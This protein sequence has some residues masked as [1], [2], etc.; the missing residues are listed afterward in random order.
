MS[1]PGQNDVVKVLDLCKPSYVTE[2]ND[3]LACF[4]RFIRRGTLLEWCKI[5]PENIGAN[6][7]IQTI[8][9]L[10]GSAEATPP[11]RP[12]NTPKPPHETYFQCISNN[13]RSQ[14][15]KRIALRTVGTHLAP[16]NDL[17]RSIEGSTSTWTDP[18]AQ[19][20]A[21]YREIHKLSDQA[22]ISY[23]FHLIFFGNSIDQIAASSDLPLEKGQKGQSYAFKAIAKAQKTTK[24]AVGKMYFHSSVYLGLAEQGGPG[25]L[26]SI[27]GVKSDMECLNQDDIQMLCN[28]FREC[29]PDLERQSRALDFE[30]A[31]RLTKWLLA[32]GMKGEDII[33]KRT[34]LTKLVCRYVD[35][36]LLVQDGKIL[37]NLASMDSSEHLRRTSSQSPTIPGSGM[38]VSPPSQ[39]MSPDP[40]GPI[41]FF[42]ALKRPQ[43]YRAAE[44]YTNTAKRRRVSGN[45][46]LQT[47][48]V[49]PTLMP[50]SNGSTTQAEGQHF[51][52]DISIHP[53]QQHNSA[54]I[55]RRNISATFN[56]AS[57]SSFTRREASGLA[58]S[59][60]EE[61][62][63]TNTTANHGDLLG[64]STTNTVDGLRGGITNNLTIEDSTGNSMQL[65]NEHGSSESS[66]IDRACESRLQSTTPTHTSKPKHIELDSGIGE[67]S[68]PIRLSDYI[69]PDMFE[70]I[71]EWE[72]V[73]APG[74][75]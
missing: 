45:E 11:H 41:S 17:L 32:Q 20:Q 51:S 38:D 6:D 16:E 22:G 34:R 29:L 52:T 55:E 35:T 69:N 43:S 12:Q 61:T 53:E 3:L 31:K 10:R 44:T 1:F 70:D 14:R 66:L 13:T 4:R 19:A 72:T 9:E 59:D 57:E 58:D 8:R 64:P 24:K 33:Q 54:P 62:I 50:E 18:I 26:L 21:M 56:M 47:P 40:Q 5:L 23:R 37:P 7:V 46:G 30:V 68:T 27:F 63:D 71:R 42:H 65:I 25:S 75:T 2:D 73:W 15:L 39:T 60:N 28:Y 67:S 49:L 36:S 74:E 48:A